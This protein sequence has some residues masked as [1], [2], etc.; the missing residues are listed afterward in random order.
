[1]ANR[2]KMAEAQSII[3]LARM[4][5]SYRRIAAEVGVDRGTVSRHVR[6]A[7]GDLD[8]ADPNA[9]TSITGSEHLRPVG[10]RSRCEPQRAIILAKLEQGLT[11]Q[12]IWQDLR[13]EHGFTDSYQSVQR[14]VKRLGAGSPLPFRRME[15]E[16]GGEAQVDFGR[17]APVKLIGDVPS[18]TAILDRFLHNAEV[19]AIA[20]RSYRLRNRTDKDQT[21][22]AQPAAASSS[23][24]S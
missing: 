17:G 2:L 9:A 20:G 22:V 6:A 3:A 7:L 5:W 21:P 4:G 13:D 1:M 24:E 19:I 15:C 14:F 18:A 8:G 11:A 12:R 16:P 10:Q 23:T